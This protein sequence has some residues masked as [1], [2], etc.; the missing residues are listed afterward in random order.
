MTLLLGV[1]D[2]PGLVDLAGVEA[3]VS[4]Q[5]SAAVGKRRGVEA[6]L[7]KG[8]AHR[9]PQAIAEAL[10]ATEGT[11]L[12]AAAI[13]AAVAVAL[14]ALVQAKGRQRI[15]IDAA[16][17]AA[18]VST[19]ADTIRTRCNALREART[20]ADVA[21]FTAE[22]RAHPAL[23]VEELRRGLV[24]TRPHLTHRY[25]TEVLR[26]KLADVTVRTVDRMGDEPLLLL[27]ADAARAMHA[28][29]VGTTEADIWKCIFT[30]RPNLKWQFGE[31]PPTQKDF[32]AL[33]AAY[34]FVP[35]WPGGTKTA[36]SEGVPHEV[37][38]R[39]DELCAIDR[40]VTLFA[41]NFGDGPPLCEGGR[42]FLS[43]DHPLADKLALYTHMILREGARGSDIGVVWKPYPAS[44]LVPEVMERCLGV[45]GEVAA[46]EDDIARRFEKLVRAR[47]PDMSPGE[48]FLH[49]G[50]A[51]W[52][53]LVEVAA[54]APHL[55]FCV[56]AHTTA[57]V[58]PVR[59]A[60][61]EPLAVTAMADGDAKIRYERMLFA[62]SFERMLGTLDVDVPRA[63]PPLSARHVVVHGGLGRIIGLG[64]LDAVAY[65][66]E[67]ARAYQRPEPFPHITVVDP[68]AAD[69]ARA[70]E[71]EA[72][73]RAGI[74]VVASTKPPAELLRGAP[75]LVVNAT[76]HDVWGPA[77]L[78]AVGADDVAVM[79]LGSGTRGFS[80]DW[81]VSRASAPEDLGGTGE[82]RSVRYTVAR[83]GQAP[84]TVT[85]LADFF[86]YNL[87]VTSPNGQEYSAFNGLLIVESLRLARENHAVG[88]LGLQPLSTVRV[89][90]SAQGRPIV[91]LLA[92]DVS[93]ALPW[94]AR[95]G[96]EMPGAHTTTPIG[97]VKLRGPDHSPL[98]L[99]RLLRQRY[100]PALHGLPP[101]PP[102]IRSR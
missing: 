91:A 70:D 39:L 22:V 60:G 27:A 33:Q 18:A 9:V 97:L 84:L 4:A 98:T 41:T 17:V 89:S 80:K 87:S 12:D 31:T 57:D 96:D 6:L 25:V 13:G 76:P 8:A 20:R 94:P 75:L 56:A 47:V 83:P 73:R 26:P 61:L 7:S 78:G 64:F 14:G 24:A 28:A 101:I 42:H 90:S 99:A 3:W 65:V 5:R 102:D 11:A 46:N 34:P 40:E 88:K 32:A 72:L 30:V 2:A 54:G 35:R 95:W 92:P 53:W 21:L 36:A 29:D 93:A 50:I 38:Q 71:V 62:S 19:H 1:H 81:V 67:A 86:P 55:A 58:E 59:G 77:E 68:A 79:N 82:P 37:T 74:T 23:S 49:V 48:V 52:D 85:A 100:D 44:P 69:P 16:D 63:E 10:V 45:R 15:V 43:V 66:R 51:R